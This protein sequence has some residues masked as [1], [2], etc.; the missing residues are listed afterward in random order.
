MLKNKVQHVKSVPVLLTGVTE[1]NTQQLPGHI[2]TWTEN[3]ILHLQRYYNIFGPQFWFNCQLCL[4]VAI[5]YF[6]VENAYTEF[7]ISLSEA[8]NLYKNREFY[9]LFFPQERT[10]VLAGT[11][12]WR[13]QDDNIAGPNVASTVQRYVHSSIIGC[14]MF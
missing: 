6:V 11:G 12:T 1:N 9:I 14:I 5:L 8:I 10:G 2:P 13:H 3:K 7:F 4:K